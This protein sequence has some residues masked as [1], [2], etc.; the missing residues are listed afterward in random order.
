MD[1]LVDSQ[2]FVVVKT[3]KIDKPRVDAVVVQDVHR[4]P[5]RVRLA[6]RG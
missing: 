4:I 5:S 6:D 3:A 1:P 2:R